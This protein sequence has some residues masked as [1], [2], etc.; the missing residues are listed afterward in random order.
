MNECI[1]IWIVQVPILFPL[2]K[3]HTEGQQQK[4]HQSLPTTI[5]ESE[6]FVSL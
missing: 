5:Y 2:L 3:V 4:V 1:Q 6:K